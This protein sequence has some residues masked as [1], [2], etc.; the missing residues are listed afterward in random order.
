M[1]DSFMKDTKIVIIEDDEIFRDAFGLLVNSSSHYEVVKTYCN[2]E[3][4]IEHLH[5]DMPQIIIMDIK[6]PG[7]NGIEATKI[8]KNLAPKINILI[9]SGNNDRRIALEAFSAG[10]IG[11]IT[12]D[13]EYIDF[14]EAI[15]QVA[16]GGAP[17]SKSI[18]RFVVESFQTNFDSPLSE[19]EAQVL[20]LLSQGKTYKE[21]AELLFIHPETVKSHLKNIYTKLNV[22]NKADAIMKAV[23]EKLIRH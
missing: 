3:E 5:E 14:M 20:Q 19:R 22:H 6:L 16:E 2:C 13:A 21:I 9:I 17:M 15:R 23:Q 18:S 8:I 10:A 4:A 7:M 1:G 11:F 12:K